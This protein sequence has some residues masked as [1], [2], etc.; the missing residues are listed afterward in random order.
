MRA[1]IG[2]A[3]GACRA[4][5]KAV[6]EFVLATASGKG[7]RQEIDHALIIGLLA[8]QAI[9]HLCCAVEIL[10]LDVDDRSQQ[11]CGGDTLALQFRAIEKIARQRQLSASRRNDC[12][13]E[14][15]S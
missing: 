15:A 4:L 3:I 12:L 7:Q 13:D 1:Q 9:Q 2:R 10:V 8:V 6:H 5:A 14:Q 11:H